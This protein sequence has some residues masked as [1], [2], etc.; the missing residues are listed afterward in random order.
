[1]IVHQHLHN[2]SST[3]RMFSFAAVSRSLAA[4]QLHRC[5]F[6]RSQFTI[7]PQHMVRHL[8]YLQQ[9]GAVSFSTHHVRTRTTPADL[10]NEHIPPELVAQTVTIYKS[11]KFA[12]GEEVQSK[13]SQA[14]R[15]LIIE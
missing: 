12:I 8:A 5:R 3:I 7:S 14:Q 6:L 11:P 1:M 4:S 13:R 2:I 15:C 9:R 10:L